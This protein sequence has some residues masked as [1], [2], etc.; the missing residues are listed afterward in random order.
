MISVTTCSNLFWSIKPYL[1]PFLSSY[2]CLP[3]PYTST[4]LPSYVPLCQSFSS[5]LPIFPSSYLPPPYTS[6]FYPS[7]PL[8]LQISLRQSRITDRNAQPITPTESITHKPGCSRYSASRLPFVLFRLV[9][10]FTS[11]L[12]RLGYRALFHPTLNSR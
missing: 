2:M 10:T 9:S 1:P 7:T 12:P 6:T 11:L 3:P 8:S 4:F 5:Y